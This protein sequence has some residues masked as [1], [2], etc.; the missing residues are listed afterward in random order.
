MSK[1]QVSKG[2]FFLAAFLSFLLSVYLF[3]LVGSP[4]TGNLCRLVGAV[5]SF[6]RY[7]AVQQ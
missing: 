1:R 5:D 6:A 3:F 4:G 7:P 2:L